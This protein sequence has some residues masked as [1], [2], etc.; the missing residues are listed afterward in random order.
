MSLTMA[1][2]G[3]QAM[4]LAGASAEI[5]A[6]ESLM[7][8]V[9]PPD[10]VV[11][12]ASRVL[13]SGGRLWCTTANRWSIGPDP[14]LGVPWAGWW[15][16]ALA[17]RYARW[18]GQV[19]PVRCLLGAGDVT[20]L[21]ARHGLEHVMIE[22]ASIATSQRDSAPGIVRLAV[23]TYG[24]IARN[25]VGRRLLTMVGPTLVITAERTSGHR[26]AS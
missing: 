23:D 22:P 25:A 26:A 1:C 18:R 2:A 21:L 10:P 19:P 8:N 14:H 12:E 9:V 11:A 15:P 5:V 3:A 17:A 16:P 4:P 7:E 24:L 20:R 6:M 13:R